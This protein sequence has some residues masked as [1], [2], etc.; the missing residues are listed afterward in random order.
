MKWFIIEGSIGSGKST[1]LTHLESTNVETIQ[2]PVNVWRSL[3]DENGCSLLDLFY[4][5]PLRYAYLFQTMVFKTRLKSLD[6]PQIKN[7]RISERSVWTD[8]YIFME[9]MKNTN[10]ISKIEQECY[11]AWYDWLTNAFF[12]QPDGIIYI[13][14]SP[15]VCLLRIKERGRN[16]ET[17]ISIEYL[18]ELHECHDKWLGNWTKT[19]VYIIQ[20]DIDTPLESI[21]NEIKNIINKKN[22]RKFLWR[23]I[24][25]I[26]SF[27]ITFK[28]LD[29]F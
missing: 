22:S 19:P 1:I 3:K 4:K 5:N 28:V 10:S 14:S 13:R 11:D 20:N 21:V 7:I 29:Y 17:S 16:E 23:C 2:E 9:A 18:K 25:F 24:I 27:I 12:K 8:R 26:V 15:E 6:T